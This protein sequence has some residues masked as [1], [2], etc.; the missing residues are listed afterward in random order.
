MKKF[1]LI[2]SFLLMLTSLGFATTYED[3][4]DKSTKRWQVLEYTASGK[5]SNDY[6]KVKSSRVIKLDGKGTQTAYMLMS[7]DGASWDNQDE[8]FLHWQM[9]YSEDFVIIVGLNTKE[10]KRYLIYTPGTKNGYMQYGL[11]KEATDGVWRRYTRNLQKDLERFDNMNYINS[12]ETF[13]I[14][15]SGKIDNVK[16]MKKHFQEEERVKKKPSVKKSK[17]KV[18]SKKHKHKKSS[19]SKKHKY[20]K[21]HKKNSKSKKHNHKKKHKKSLKS[22]SK[23]KIIKKHRT[24]S[25][26]VIHLKGPNPFHLA[27]GVVFVEPGVTAED[28]EDG[29]LN[30]TSSE[31]IDI[32]KEG[33][34]SIMYIATDS[35]GN[36]AVDTRFVDVGKGQGAE[37]EKKS[38]RRE[39]LNYS[40]QLSEDNGDDMY[41][42]SEAEELLEE[43]ELEIAEWEKE[44]E[45]R[46]QE[47]N[48]RE[49][50]LQNSMQLQEGMYER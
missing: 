30:V 13:V 43:R 4:E 2:L 35:Q 20:K 31:N 37:S 24:N 6:D 8:H 16:M 1:N 25:T 17:K 26:P 29:K 28:K 49:K 47:I 46:E 36:S 18:S 48:D 40:Q 5:V 3:A 11:G 34:Y 44:L 27:K 42:G 7:N 38:P 19:K 45:L 33:R 9:N 10:G 50:N 21:K 15:G 41:G 23:R 14:R 39:Q 32:Y 12:V 22:K